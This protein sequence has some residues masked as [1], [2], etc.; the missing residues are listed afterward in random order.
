MGTTQAL[1]A[2]LLEGHGEAQ[3]KLVVSLVRICGLLVMALGLLGG[4]AVWQGLGPFD[5][6]PDGP[7]RVAGLVDSDPS[8]GIA[9]CFLETS[10]GAVRVVVGTRGCFG[11]SDSS[12]ELTTER[13]EWQ[14]ATR[15]W[16]DYSHHRV[17]A[18]TVDANDAEHLIDGIEDALEQPLF[19][20]STC[21]S[22]GE[23]FARVTVRCGTEVYEPLMLESRECLPWPEDKVYFGPKSRAVQ[24]WNWGREVLATRTTA[25]L[26]E[27]SAEERAR[28]DMKWGSLYKDGWRARHDPIEAWDLDEQEK[29]QVK[30]ESTR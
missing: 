1:A 12:I 24:V 19:R 23:V 6:G 22:T 29:A 15:E 13:G 28:T 4:V 11:G 16:A 9:E 27:H 14:L 20:V 30:P 25:R 10:D 7:F 26:V 5:P 3:M 8:R 2:L 18:E 17:L 21:A